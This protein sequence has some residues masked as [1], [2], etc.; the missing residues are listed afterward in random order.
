MAFIGGTQV[1]QNSSGNALVMAAIIIGIA[2]VGSSYL[3]TQSVDRASTQLEQSFTALKA[4]K[5]AAAPARAAAPS[6]KPDPA[7]IYKVAVG[8]APFKGPAK[9]DITIVE[10]TDFQ[11]PFCS[12]VGPTLAKIQE[13]YGD[14]VR[15]VFKHMPLSFHAQ[16]PGAH[17]AAEAAKIQGKF[18]EMHDKIFAN[19][20]DLAVATLERYAQEIGLDIEK[21]KKDVAS[22]AVKDQVAADTRQASSLGVTGTP[23]F[24]INGRFL[25]GAQP[26]SSFKRVIDAELKG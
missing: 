20:R 23:G 2:M 7:K 12:R 11:C 21:F 5:P 10:F 25:S 19:Q 6:G 13:E 15:I 1:A 22:K 3:L 26:F 16:A 18:W 4:A 24:F 8:D 17:A 14:Q 9:A